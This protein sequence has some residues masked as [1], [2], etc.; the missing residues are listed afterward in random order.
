M[1]PVVVVEHEAVLEPFG[2]EV[3]FLFRDPFPQPAVRTMIWP[4]NFL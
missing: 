3:A 2:R 1:N 4:N